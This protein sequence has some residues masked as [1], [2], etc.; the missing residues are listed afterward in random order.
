MELDERE[1]GGRTSS[2]RPLPDAERTFAGACQSLPGARS[3]LLAGWTMTA[4]C[5]GVKGAPSWRRVNESLRWSVSVRSRGASGLGES[6]EKLC[7]DRWISH[8]GLYE[9]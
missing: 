6:D 9:G 4:A 5:C 8:G 3:A 1:G 2:Q 7:R